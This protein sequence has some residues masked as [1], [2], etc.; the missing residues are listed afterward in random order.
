MKKRI[1]CAL[2]ALIMLVSL[3]PVT[4]V[5][6]SAASVSNDLVEFV[7]KF[8]GFSEKCK[9]DNTQYSIGYGTVCPGSDADHK[10]SKVHTI[11]EA[12]AKA[13]L[14]KELQ[15]AADSVNKFVTKHGLSLSQNQFEALVS[16]SYN[17][18]TGWMSA[19]GIFRQAV[20]QGK[21]GNDFLYAIT[22]WSVGG[23]GL[24]KRRL[25]EANM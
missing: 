25:C 11:S 9:A 7:K 16:F 20:L 3:V 8:E 10:A 12:D 21:T 23:T 5:T 4:A 18:G 13:A 2:L 22:L 6:A 17:C 15:A 14:D 24:A 19:D 1:V